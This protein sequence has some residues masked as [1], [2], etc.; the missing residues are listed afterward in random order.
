LSVFEIDAQTRHSEASTVHRSTETEALPDT[1]DSGDDVQVQVQEQEEVVK[2][3][4][5]KRVS[6]FRNVYNYVM[7]SK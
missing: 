6:T 3:K 2:P 7:G 1:E 5:L 4:K